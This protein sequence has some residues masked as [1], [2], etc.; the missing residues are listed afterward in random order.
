M[1]KSDR[2]R[3]WNKYRQ[4][5]AYCGKHL[6]YHEM[7]VDHLIPRLRGRRS[8]SLVEVFS[9][10][11]PSCRRCNHYKHCYPLEHFRNLLLTLHKRINKLYTAR[12]AQDYGIILDAVAWDGVF[13]FEEFE[14]EE[15][16]LKALA[17]DLGDQEYLNDPLVS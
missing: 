4:R 15:K 17:D 9:N 2:L 13:Y 3:V 6:L 14:E 10:W 11:M 12:V 7:Q 16:R 5:C 8:D 1:K